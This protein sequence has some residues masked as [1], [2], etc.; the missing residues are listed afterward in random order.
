MSGSLAIS[1]V[2]RGSRFKRLS[3]VFS[4]AMMCFFAVLSFAYLTRP[5]AV[6]VSLPLPLI[7]LP[8]TFVLL[9]SSLA[10]WNA[11]RDLRAEQVRAMLRW[12]AIS[13]GL[14]AIFVV[15][16]FLAWRQW[17]RAGV[18]LA[19]APGSRFFFL[20]TAAHAVH[21]VAGLIVLSVVFSLAW[22]GRLHP[23]R[24]APLEAAAIFWH[25]LDFTWLWIFFMLARF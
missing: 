1:S 17:A 20:L 9:A 25:C 21:I 22:R 6:R 10:L 24:P 7:L 15:D 18:F 3:L 12:L 11:G 2:R 14:G 16:Q 13:V 19:T 8:N 23:D 5:A 4:L